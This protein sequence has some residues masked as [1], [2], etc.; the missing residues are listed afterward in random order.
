[1]AGVIGKD[2]LLGGIDCGAACV[3]S[4]YVLDAVDLQKA[5]FNELEIAARQSCNF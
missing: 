4:N 2:L 3:A 1:M 5:R